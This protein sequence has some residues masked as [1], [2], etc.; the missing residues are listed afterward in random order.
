MSK[1]ITITDVELKE[2]T[3]IKDGDNF[4]VN[5]SFNYVDSSGDSWPGKRIT[6]EDS[7][8]TNAQKTKI[9]QVLDVVVDKT[10]EKESI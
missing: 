3:I 6:L 2:F 9:S 1:Q 4:K 10:K 5:Y 8:L 7:D